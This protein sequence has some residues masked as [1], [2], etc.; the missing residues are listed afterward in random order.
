MRLTCL[1]VVA[2]SSLSLLSGC[3]TGTVS[4]VVPLAGGG[5]INVPMDRNGPPRGEGEGYR[6][7]IATLQ[8]GAEARETFYEFGLSS[9]NEPALRRI[10]VIDMSDEQP[11]TLVDDQH[12]EFKDRKWK[13]KT[14]VMTADDPR[15]KWVYQITLSMRAYRFVL[16]ANDGHEISFYHISTFPQFLKQAIR[17]KWGEKY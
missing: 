5:Q 6:V 10:Q 11:V 9:A 17:A 2:L 13:T 3:R 15:L 14:E 8:P 16:T 12:P 1:F 7:E 4:A